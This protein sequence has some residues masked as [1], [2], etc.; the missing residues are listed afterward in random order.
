VSKEGIHDIIA[1][2]KAAASAALAAG[3][4]AGGEGEEKGVVNNASKTTGWT[5]RRTDNLRL[6]IGCV[7]S[8]LSLPSSSS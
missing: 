3:A 4:S 2:E 5:F 8:S 1:L 6:W 7:P